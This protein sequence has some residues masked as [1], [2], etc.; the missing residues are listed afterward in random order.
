MVNL[1]TV[2]EVPELEMLNEL[3][4][5]VKKMTERLKKQIVRLEQLEEYKNE[6]IQNASHEIK[7]PITAINMALELSENSNNEEQKSGN[8]FKNLFNTR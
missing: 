4:I 2:I 1:D 5:S 6:F 7:T 8:A 3:A